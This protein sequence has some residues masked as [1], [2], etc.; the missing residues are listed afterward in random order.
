MCYFTHQL[1]TYTY[2]CSVYKPAVTIGALCTLKC[3]KSIMYCRDNNVSIGDSICK[4]YSLIINQADYYS[5][6]ILQILSIS[7]LDR[8][9]YKGNVNTLLAISLATGTSAFISL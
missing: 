7:S 5:L 6:I 2:W 4:G 3:I 9:G 1:H 8:S